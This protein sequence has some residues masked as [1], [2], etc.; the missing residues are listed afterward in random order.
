MGRGRP[1]EARIRA[2]KR[3][4][5]GSVVA[6]TSIIVATWRS[7]NAT[8][9][10]PVVGG[11]IPPVAARGPIGEVASRHVYTVK[12]EVRFLDRVLAALV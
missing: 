10:E 11:L 4:H 7:G 5:A 8:G 3:L 1:R 9:S 12:F 2:S 6:Q